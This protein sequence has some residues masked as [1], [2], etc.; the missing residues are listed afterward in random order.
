MP[1]ETITAPPPAAPAPSSLRPDATAALDSIAARLGFTS[2]EAPP[3]AEP[4]PARD[5][6]PPEPP[7]APAPT[8]PPPAEKGP[9]LPPESLLDPSKADAPP[10]KVDEVFPENPPFEIRSEKG[11]TEYRNQREVYKQME[12]ELHA[13]QAKLQ[14]RKPDDALT[15]RLQEL[16][17][18]NAEMEAAFQRTRATESPVFYKQFEK[19]IAD[20]IDA[21][22]SVI[23]ETG[24]DP[25]AFA[26]VMSVSGVERD[27]AFDNFSEN[28][29][30]PTTKLRLQRMVEE[31]GGLEDQRS[32]WLAN[33]KENLER[34][35]AAERIRQSQQ[36][37]ERKKQSAALI[38][39]LE[40]YFGTQA[41]IPFF[42]RGDGA[43]HADW[44]AGMEADKAEITRILHESKD[45]TE[46]YG[47][48][49][50]GIKFPRALS[51][52]Y[53]ERKARIAAEAKLAERDAASPDLSGTRPAPTTNGHAEAEAPKSFQREDIQSWLRSE[54][55]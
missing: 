7:T 30:S 28:I 19:P 50:M 29:E 38:D 37:E 36:F 15:A 1:E 26:S 27:R 49:W 52:Y 44:N 55:Q 32:H 11:K 35:T 24:L 53:A 16:E 40:S 21:I 25:K 6:P 12:R 47:L 54:R 45:D 31:L 51:A 10:S 48:A 2:G 3:P 17:A 23:K 4:A 46:K 41:K 34:E 39:S 18:R 13:A 20:K 14:E 8:P 5:A 9:L 22:S 33:A 42:Q 43:A